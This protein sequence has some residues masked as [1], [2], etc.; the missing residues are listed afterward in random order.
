[1]KIQW[2]IAEDI[3]RGGNLVKQMAASGEGRGMMGNMHAL[4]SMSTMMGGRMPSG[5]QHS[6]HCHHDQ[7]L[8]SKAAPDVVTGK[9]DKMDR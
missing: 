6:E 8:G 4:R 2:I 9:G 3:G 5:H 1:M 7:G